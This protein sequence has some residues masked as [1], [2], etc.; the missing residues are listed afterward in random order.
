MPDNVSLND[1]SLDIKYLTDGVYLTIFPPIGKGK[2]VDVNTVIDKLNR[3]QIKGFNRNT[4]ETAVIKAEKLPVKIAEAQQEMFSDATMSVIISPDKMK[5]YISLRAPEGGKDLTQIEILDQLEANKVTYGINK[6]TVETISKYPVYGEMICVAEG[7]LPINGQNGKVEFLFDIIKDRKPTIMDDGRVDYRELDIIENVSSGQK[8]C[9]L[10]QPIPG[11]PGKTVL[12]YDIKAID[13]KV[14]TL[15]KGRNVEFNEDGTEL[16]S[17][18]DGQVIYIEG[19]VSVFASYEVKADVDVSVGNINFVG[20]VIV[21]GNVL[22]G[23]SIEAGGNV[24]VWGVVEGAFIKAGGDIILRRGMQGLG[25]GTLISGGDII[26]RYIE[27]SNIEAKNIIKSEA[28]MHS[29]IR[30]GNKVELTG[31]KGLLVGGVCRAGK[32]VIAKVI[33]SNMATVTEIEVGIEP[34]LRERF[35]SVRE[36]INGMEADIKKAD[37]AITILRKLEAAGAL[38]PDKVEIMGKS[39]RTKVYMENR[40]KD[41]K[42]EY[43]TI[44]S[45]LQ[46]DAYGKVRIMNYVYPGT[47]VAIGSCMMFVKE[48]L[49]YCT[50]YRDGADIRVGAI[51]R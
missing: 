32:E 43:E 24:E 44:E 30:C 5:A 27:H 33:G 49:Q 39:V 38:T 18:I 42:E 46:Q 29:F 45:K 34:G 21:R 31:K 15:P 23:F 8:L 37:Q 48:L 9:Q 19:K 40:I 41:L 47:R 35:K 25:K 36:E 14:A 11:T 16:Y 26:A 20:N 22:S 1:G 2:K 17:T 3:K 4:V 7:S 50:L 10:I 13:G 6:V 51:D 28:I 12:G